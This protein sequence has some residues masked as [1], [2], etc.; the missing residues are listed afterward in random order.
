MEHGRGLKA[1]R[2]P[3][4]L[5]EIASEVGRLAVQQNGSRVVQKVLE[6]AAK[7]GADVSEPVDALLQLGPLRLAEVA[8][9]RFGNY[10]VQLALKHST[11]HRQMQLVA[12]LL[13]SIRALAISKCGSNVAEVVIALASPQQ[14]GETCATFTLEEAEELRNHPYGSF[15]MAA[16]DRR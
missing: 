4:I 12:W 7:T 14:L 1:T 11:H 13:P 10:V 16:I 9:D 5:R 15:V 6:E 3:F 2:A 8:E